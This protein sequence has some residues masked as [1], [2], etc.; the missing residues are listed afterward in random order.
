M[1]NRPAN[2]IVIK[3]G[4]KKD[5]TLVA[6]QSRVTGSGGAY[7][8]GGAGAADFVIRELYACPNVRCENQSVYTNAGPE[9]PFRAPGHPQGAWVSIPST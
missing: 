6:L 2:T 1:G 4:A 5:G 8:E 9:R 7:S 3:A